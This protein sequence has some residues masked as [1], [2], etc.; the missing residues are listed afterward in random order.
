MGWFKKLLKGLRIVKVHDSYGVGWSSG[1]PF[2]PTDQERT[3]AVNDL[4]KQKSKEEEDK[5]KKLF[6]IQEE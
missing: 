4:V 3:D 2:D 5:L 1:K 6:N